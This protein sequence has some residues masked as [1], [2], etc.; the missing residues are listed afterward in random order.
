[1]Q[2]HT[3]ER[4]RLKP[5]AA[6]LKLARANLIGYPGTFHDLNVAELL[7]MIDRWLG[8]LE[9]SGYAVNPLAPSSA[10]ALRLKEYD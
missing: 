7:G 1:M 9:A 4:P 2:K 3:T 8:K 5:A 6:L 10:P